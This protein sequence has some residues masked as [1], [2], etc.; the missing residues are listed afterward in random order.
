[1]SPD[2]VELRLAARALLAEPLV[3]RSGAS[4]P[5]IRK[6]RRE[7]ARWFADELGYRLDATRP[8]LARL[9]KL[10]GPGHQP[11]GL[12]TRG[13]RRFDG[14]R[15]ALICLVMASAEA[16]GEYTTLRHLFED[17]GLRA[18][19]VAGLAWDGRAASDRRV[20]I[21]AV[22]ALQD[23]GVFEKADGDEEGFARG[24]D[25]GDALYRIDRDRLSLL[26]TTAQPPSLAGGPE[27]VAVEPYPDTEQGR[28]LRRRHRVT[29]ALVEEP[30]L[31]RADLT[32]E[33]LEYLR[34]QRGRLEG[35]LVDRL[36][37]TLEVRAEGW[38]T[39]DESGELSDLRWPDYGAPQT[40]ALRLCD[41]LRA[42]HVRQ[43]PDDWPMTDVVAFV[44]DLA[45][46]YA[47]Y[48]KK[49]V[50]D[51][52]GSL[53]LADEAVAIL[54]AARVAARV[55]G[56]ALAPLPAAARFAAAKPVGPAPVLPAV[57]RED[58]AAFGAHSPYGESSEEELP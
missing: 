42:R 57:G 38:V 31:Y 51:D 30:V 56:P 54:V 2:P 44:R 39:I 52:A 26:P 3:D 13:G 48:W 34:S 49:G 9:A 45:S 47:G 20:F 24:D 27:D 6:H 25:A 16:A 33:E 7:L 19:A 4:F 50:D 5:L 17:V 12:A 32:D 46:E 8:A 40:T 53:R 23:L 36:G 37:L 28:V 14:R 1:M 10:P 11:R 22:Q 15:Y 35:L 18:S 29:R 43:D 55:T 58:A 21:Q 41:E